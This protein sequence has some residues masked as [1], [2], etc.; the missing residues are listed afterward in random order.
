MATAR[1]VHHY[2]DGSSDAFSFR[3]DSSY[4]DA[5]AEAVARTLDLFRAVCQDDDEP[6]VEL[7]P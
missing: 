3:I 1:I 5:C 2:P 6:D 7:E 4:P